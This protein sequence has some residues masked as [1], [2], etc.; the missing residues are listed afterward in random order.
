MLILSS[1]AND[2]ILIMLHLKNMI[3]KNCFGLFSNFQN[4]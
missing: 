3:L 2:Q 1:V 4:F